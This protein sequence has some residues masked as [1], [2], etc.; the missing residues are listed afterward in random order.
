MYER[1][2]K[3]FVRLIIIPYL[4]SETLRDLSHLDTIQDNNPRYN[5]FL[6]CIWK[7]RNFQNRNGDIDFEAIERAL[8]DAIGREVGST[9]PGMNLS[10]VEAERI[11]RECNQLGGLNHGQKV[12]RVRNCILTRIKKFGGI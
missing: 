2:E 12:V 5:S 4:T 8:T 3:A 6:S 1:E 9:G 7:D 10:K 11:V